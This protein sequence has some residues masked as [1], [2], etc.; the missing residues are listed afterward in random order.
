M[1]IVMGGSARVT[2]LTRDIA[3]AIAIIIIIIIYNGYNNN[4]KKTV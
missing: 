1:N 4:S 2:I 3:I